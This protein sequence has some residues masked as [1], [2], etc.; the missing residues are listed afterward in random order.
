MIVP[1]G[2]STIAVALGMATAVPDKHTDPNDGSMIVELRSTGTQTVVGPSIHPDGETYESLDA[3][4][5]TV[6]APNG[7][8]PLNS[9]MFIS[10]WQA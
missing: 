4:P 7:D 2:R 3:D 9:E 8:P 6:P 10:S 5:A 1:D